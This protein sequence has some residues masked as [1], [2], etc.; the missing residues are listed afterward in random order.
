MAAYTGLT[1]A[2]TAAPTRLVTST[3]MVVGAYTVANASP[4]WQG[5]G[6]VTITHT[7]VGAADTLGT[8]S[9]V[10]TDL[11]G[12]VR[13]DVI[14]PIASSVATGVI[15]FRTVT[16]ITGAGWVINAGN[17]TVTM[18]FAA[19]SI[20]CGTDGVLFAIVVNTTAASSIVVSDKNNTIATLKASIAEGHYIYGSGLDFV[21][22]LKVALTGAND[23]TVIASATRPSGI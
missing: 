17:D 22:Y 23:I 18:G 11:A 10:G 6:L 8:V 14:T 3:N 1:A 5:G 19:G 13:T 20:V 16:A 9:V 2:T 4:T 12:N 21:G 7:A 15:P